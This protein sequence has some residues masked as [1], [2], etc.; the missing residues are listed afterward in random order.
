MNAH[1]MKI[2]RYEIHNLLRSRWLLAMGA[3]LFVLAEVLFRFGGGAERAV[4]SLTNVV[5]LLVPLVSLVLGTVYFYNSREF[6]ELLLAQPTSR[7]AIYAGKLAGFTTALSLVFVAGMGTPFLIHSYQLSVYATKIAALMLVGIAFITIFTAVA[8]LT[9]TRHDEK[10]KGL[11]LV[12]V[13]WLFVTVI[14]DGVVLLFVHFFRSYPFDTP[15]LALI[16]VNPVD[17]GR[18]LIL[19]QLDISSL[20]GYTGA[21]FQKTFGTHWGV[22]LSALV[23]AIWAAAPVVLGL[24]SFRRKDF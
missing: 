23:L 19:L 21:V 17:L 5:L 15:L 16:M 2:L 11:G 14:Y 20:M 9:A 13:Y 8:F 18:V 7:A 12:L 24:R 22:G 6:N 10:I 1:A 3:L 4:A